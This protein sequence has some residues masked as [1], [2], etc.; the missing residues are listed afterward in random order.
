[1]HSTALDMARFL[2]AEIA[3]ADK[4]TSRLARAMALTQT[5]QRNLDD[6]PKHGALGLAWQIRPDGTIWHNGQT[7]GHHSLIA[8]MPSQRIGVVVL[9]SGA[10]AMID[11]VGVAALS[12]LQGAAVPAG[13]EL[14]PPDV[15][16]DDKTL[17]TYVGSYEL[18][19]GLTI[20]VSHHDGKLYAQT[21]DL[22]QIQLHPT[23]P[24]EFWAHVVPA[25][26]TFELDAKRNPTGVLLHLGGKDQRA[27]RR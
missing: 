8:F 22:P 27:R 25:R 19:A 2:Q 10:A 18:G 7:E 13:L 16:V 21:P 12:V 14:P 17:E 20:N 11:F 15:A 26:L 6:N 1:L 23:S 24:T 4:P 5:P 9:A 3:A